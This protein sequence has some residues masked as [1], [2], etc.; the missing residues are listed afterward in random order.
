MKAA[1]L[2]LL[3]L[4]YALFPL[5]ASESL[6]DDLQPYQMVR[7]LQNLQDRIADGDHAVMPMQNKLLAMIDTRL[8]ATTAQEFKDRRNVYALLVYAMSGGNPRTASELLPM[9]D[10][11]IAS[12]ALI[13]GIRAHAEGRPGAALPALLKFNPMSLAPEIGAPLALLLGNLVSSVDKA[14]AARYLDMARLLAP[15]T[16]IEEAAL[17]RTLDLSLQMDD[18]ERFRNAASE[19]VRRFILSP[20]AGQFASG[21]I[22]GVLK[23]DDQIAFSEIAELA[24]EMGLERR[25]YIFLELARFAAIEG[26]NELARMASEKAQTTGQEPGEHDA[27]RAQLYS[28]VS[29]VAMENVEETME[30]LHAIDRDKLNRDDRHLLDAALNVAATM[31]APPL[32]AKPA[33]QLDA[34]IVEDTTPARPLRDVPPDSR[35]ERSR[36]MLADIDRLLEGR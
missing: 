10:P 21:F 29:S 6:D 4:G 30:R 18:P 32:A 17:R 14:H 28:S 36:A 9:V 13:E 7:S 23:F 22:N 11:T 8:R 26:K 2:A 35:L 5:A 24:N 27:M 15:G 16:L 33:D 19:Y 3:L 12:P 31:L 1:S 20:Y 25:Q 34:V